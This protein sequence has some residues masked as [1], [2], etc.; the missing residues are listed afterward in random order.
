[1]FGEAVMSLPATTLT[2]LRQDADAETRSCLPGDYVIGRGVEADIRIETPLI[3][4]AHARLII[5]ERECLIEDLGS[6][7]GTFV[8]G[9]R[10]GTVTVLRPEER[11]MLGPSVTLEIRQLPG[12]APALSV[13]SRRTALVK[14]LPPEF[15]HEKKYEIGNV[16][17]E[18]GMGAV[19]DARELTIQRNVAMKVMLESEKP[20]EMMRFIAEAKI[21]GQLEHPNIMPV[22]ELGV[23]DKERLFYT[24]KYVRGCTLRQVLDALSDRDPVAIAKYPFGHL[25]T[26]LQKVCD[27]VAFAHSKG[28]IHRDLKPENFM[29]GDY[30]EV[31]VMDWGLAKVLDPTEHRAVSYEG[32]SIIRTGL[33][34][35]LHASEKESGHVFG[36]PQYMAPEQAYAQHEAIDVR[37]DV[38]AL[39]AILHHLLTLRHPIQGES[40]QAILTKVAAGDFRPA[41]EATTGATRLPHLPH[42]KV[43]EALSAVALK[44]M[45]NSPGRRYQTVRELQA[46]IDAY[47]AGFATTAENA[48]AVKQTVL[49]LKRQRLVAGVAIAAVATLAVFA[50]QLIRDRHEAEQTL[51]RLRTAAPALAEQARTFLTHGQTHEA[52]EKIAYAVDLAPEKEEYVRLQG[53]ALTADLE[54]SAAAAAYRHALA[55]R[56]DDPL[57]RNSLTLLDRLLS[58]HPNGDGLTQRDFKELASLAQQQGRPEAGIYRTLA[59]TTR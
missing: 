47:Q 49:L 16:I 8:N 58:D 12:P 2:I 32:H 41:R 19:L 51:Q 35:E 28:V 14:L 18:G 36:T 6:S 53:D 17:A 26:I 52:V 13:A 48:G 7:N 45:A 50:A 29:I 23:D 21:T 59:A 55:L 9:E 30:G 22:H 39:G 40:A 34:A 11:I 38:Y 25:L 4:R 33:R 3:S 46:D 15:L 43:P 1:M 54:L 56:A 42:G 10:I 44:A 37:T 20:D 31:L 5:R 57:A 24:M 27:A